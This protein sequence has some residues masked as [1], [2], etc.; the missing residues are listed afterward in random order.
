MFVVSFR[1][2][3][4]NRTLYILMINDEKYVLSNFSGKF[5]WK[6][7]NIIPIFEQKEEKVRII[8]RAEE[9]TWLVEE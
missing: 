5:E 9:H 6:G 1:N 2:S 8:Q 7:N 3:K 4:E